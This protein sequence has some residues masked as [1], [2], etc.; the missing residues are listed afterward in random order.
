MQKSEK[1]WN[2]DKGRFLTF[3]VLK[4]NFNSM[5]DE[6]DFKQKVGKIHQTYIDILNEFKEE[7]NIQGHSLFSISHQKIAEDNKYNLNSLIKKLIEIIKRID[8]FT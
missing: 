1:F 7:G 6:S 5:K 2:Q 3:E 4:K 8:N